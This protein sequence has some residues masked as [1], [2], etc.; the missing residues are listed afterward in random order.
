MNQ[1]NFFE[2]CG[3]DIHQQ[4]FETT[5]LQNPSQAKKHKHKLM[6]E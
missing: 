3:L 2:I 4:T 5:M 1:S 6:V